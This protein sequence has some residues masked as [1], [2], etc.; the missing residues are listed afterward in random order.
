MNM[1]MS[2]PEKREADAPL[3]GLRVVEFGQFIA[4]PA[5][6]QTLAELGADVIKVEPPGGDASRFTGWRQDEFGPMFSAYNRGKRSVVLNLR[7]EA[8][9]DQALALAASADVVLQNA[10]PG[11]MD[12]IGLGADD[13]LARSSRVIYGSVSGFGH[14]GAAAARPG[15]D[16]AAQAES[17][18]MSLNGELHA[19]PMRVGFAVV[20]VMASH[21]LV[22][23]VLAALIRR[24]T[25]GRGSRVDV[26]LIDVALEALSQSWAEYRLTG[27][28][29]LRCGN[30]QPTVAPAADL[31][32]TANGQVVVSAYLDDHFARLCECL[33]RKDLAADSRFADNAGRVANRAALR[34]E[35]GEVLRGIRSE[36]VCELLTRAG[37]VSGAVR[38]L[39]E[40]DGGC[41]EHAFV[42]VA[43]VGRNDIALP[44][45]P[46]RI[47]LM[48]RDGGSLP[49]I[50][51]HT[52]EVLAE[53]Y[54][55]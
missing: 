27:N 9:R 26:S 37:V 54:A 12:R 16:I 24:G 14:E 18:M 10:R 31:I 43:A 20:D 21:A 11:V 4:V 6:A 28:V 41:D 23:G 52:Y 7:V 40:I 33:G 30:G 17:G 47:D 50:G 55:E 8:Q 34:A 15:F 44:G 29:P 42:P 5:A 51:Q 35:L 25:K 45:L 22:T 46:L 39:A 48:R 38:T 19:D 1:M 36:E 32:A 13:L 3:K 2:E 53:L 49:T